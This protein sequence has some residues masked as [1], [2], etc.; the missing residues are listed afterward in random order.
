MLFFDKLFHADKER[1]PNFNSLHLNLRNLI[2]VEQI[3]AVLK[4]KIYLLPFE[5]S[6]PPPS[7]VQFSFQFQTSN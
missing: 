1:T 3:A 5:A 6:F 4:V 7:V 2:A